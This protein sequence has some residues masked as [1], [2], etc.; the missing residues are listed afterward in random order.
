MTG[1]NTIKRA[2]WGHWNLPYAELWAFSTVS[3][4]GTLMGFRCTVIAQR[5]RCKMR[6]RAREV[7]LQNQLLKK[8]QFLL[9]ICHGQYLRLNVLLV[10]VGCFVLLQPIRHF[11]YLSFFLHKPTSPW[12]IQ[13]L[14]SH[15]DE[16]RVWLTVSKK[17]K[18]LRLPGPHMFAKF[19]LWPIKAQFCQQVQLCGFWSNSSGE[20]RGWNWAVPG[21]WT[22]SSRQDQSAV[23]REQH[24]RM[25]VG[26]EYASDSLV[27]VMWIQCRRAKLWSAGYGRGSHWGAILGYFRLSCRNL[28]SVNCLHRGRQRRGGLKAI[29]RLV[30][31][32]RALNRF[33][34][35]FQVRTRDD[36]CINKTHDQRK[37]SR[38]QRKDTANWYQSQEKQ[39]R[40]QIYKWFAPSCSSHAF[41]CHCRQWGWRSG[42]TVDETLSKTVVKPQGVCKLNY[43]T[44]FAVHITECRTCCQST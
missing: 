9:L 4:T 29:S 38:R 12:H 7:S 41:S 33:C 14:T 19:W 22:A 21:A 1:T 13:R 30:S 20:W 18:Y 5:H 36:T 35:T 44:P 8:N 25:L 17:W 6:F 11:H 42:L 28:K 34:S 26:W 15:Q 10:I 39:K 3:H 43:R 16:R 24:S 40:R 2:C 37:C 31:G 23:D 32:T 27:L